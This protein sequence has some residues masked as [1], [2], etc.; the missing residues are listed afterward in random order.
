[1]DRDDYRHVSHAI[2]E[3]MAASWEREQDWI[4]SVS[5]T[6]SEGMIGM[7]DPQPGQTILELAAGAGESGF[8]AAARIG[9]QGRL[10]STDFAAE[11]VGAARRRAE[12]LGLTNVEFREMD[13]ERM[14]LDDDSVDGVLCRWGY[15]LMADPAAALAETRRVLRAG[16][17][18]CLSVW[19]EPAR[20]QWAVIA[21]RAL[22]AHGHLTPPEPGAPGLFAMADP[23]RIEA[24]VTGAGFGPPQI[25]E[26]PIAWRFRDFDGYWSFLA[27]FAGA[28]AL[29]LARLGDEETAQVRAAI[30][31]DAE[32]FR[33]NGAYTFPGVALNAVAS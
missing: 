17:R 1:M 29:V 15:M 19:A 11:M 26:A 28:I 32:P 5:R 21:S 27:D 33:E 3:R 20:N 2:W 16:G 14:A 18:V 10:I 7:L 9:D 23:A 24:L 4:W 31:R 30:M 6:V 12:Q 25:E 8:A 13:A 22:V